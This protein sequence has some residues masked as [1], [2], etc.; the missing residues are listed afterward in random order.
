[1]K[2]IC[3][4]C[5]SEDINYIGEIPPIL[6][7]LPVEINKPSFLFN[8]SL[9]SC[10]SCNLYF[11]WPQVSKEILNYLYQKANYQ[12]RSRKDWEIAAKWLNSNCTKKTILDIGCFEGGFLEYLGKDWKRYGVEINEKAIQKAKEKG[13]TIIGK[14]FNQMDKLSQ[15]FEAVIAMD[16]IEH[17]ENPL[18]FFLKLIEVTFSKGFIIISSGDTSAFSWKIMGSHYWYCM[19]PGHISFINEI[20]CFNIAKIFKTPIIYMRRFSH[21]ENDSSIKFLN[22]WF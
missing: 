16:I 6:I 11:R 17:T 8:S 4:S 7:N 18:K 10:N 9:Y 3:P 1:M 2:L 20:W 13:I 5:K 14:D 22:R 19:F 12:T 15:K 21:S